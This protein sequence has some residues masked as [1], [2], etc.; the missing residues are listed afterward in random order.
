MI[1][2]YHMRLWDAISGPYLAAIGNWSWFNWRIGVWTSSCFPSRRTRISSINSLL[3]TFLL[4]LQRFSNPSPHC[5][6]SN[7]TDSQEMLYDVEICTQASQR[8]KESLQWRVAI[9]PLMGRGGNSDPVKRSSSSAGTSS[10]RQIF[11]K[12]FSFRWDSYFWAGPMHIT[13]FR[14][15]RFLIHASQLLLSGHVSS[16]LWSNISMVTRPEA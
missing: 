15:W 9:R 7:Q 1:I 6:T 2:S 3:L 5:I 11:T 14:F 10:L 16:S 4:L 13:K 8:D 12:H